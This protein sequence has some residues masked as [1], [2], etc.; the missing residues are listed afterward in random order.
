MTLDES[1]REAVAAATEP[2][3][4][5]IRMLRER[6]DKSLP[7]QFGSMDD[8]AAILGCCR[9]TVKALIKRGEI[10]PK[11]VGKRVL[12]DLVAL[13]PPTQDEVDHEVWKARAVR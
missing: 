9:S 8:A 10:L 7:T 6:L 3:A 1:L 13:K 12:I 4:R 2:L 11:R 5:E